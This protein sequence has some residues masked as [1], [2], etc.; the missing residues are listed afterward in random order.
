MAILKDG[1]VADA[2]ELVPMQLSLQSIDS[3]RLRQVLARKAKKQ[4]WLSNHF[5]DEPVGSILSEFDLP[6][7]ES[8]L[9]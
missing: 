5:S 9:I 3:P 1:D 2:D 6:R 4:A 7:T 8:M